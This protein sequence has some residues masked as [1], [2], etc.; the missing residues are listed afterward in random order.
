[1]MDADASPST[2]LNDYLNETSS[3]RE[4]VDNEKSVVQ[5]NCSRISLPPVSGKANRFLRVVSRRRLVPVAVR[6]D[7]LKQ[8]P[9][10]VAHFDVQEIERSC[11]TFA[12]TAVEPESQIFCN[13]SAL[14][15]RSIGG[16]RALGCVV[17]HVATAAP[18]E[19]SR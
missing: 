3:I 13:V 4:V 9:A 5:R 12:R 17:T 2:S 6:G 1:M 19:S 8:C 7:G 14:E 16:F 18:D 10:G 15:R 11:R